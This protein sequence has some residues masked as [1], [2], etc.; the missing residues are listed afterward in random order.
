MRARESAREREEEKERERERVCVCVC[1]LQDENALLNFFGATK[2]STFCHNI[3]N[4]Y[5]SS[6]CRF[7]FGA[8]G[9]NRRLVLD[10]WLMKR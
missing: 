7:F 9:E 8:R 5:A 2:R 4:A 3:E 10:S 1:L 6:T